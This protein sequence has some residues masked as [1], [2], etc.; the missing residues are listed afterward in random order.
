M[1]DPKPMLP[2]TTGA[3]A[4]LTGARLV[5]PDNIEITSVDSAEVARPGTLTFARSAKYVRTF[6]ESQA[7]AA[8]VNADAVSPDRPPTLPEG[9]ALLVVPSADHAIARLLDALTPRTEVIPGVDASAIISP[10]ARIDPT[11]RVDAYAVIG[12]GTEIGPRVSVG[13]GVVI[14]RNC[15][16]GEGTTI[17]PRVTLYDKVSIGRRCIIHAGVVMGSDGFGFLPAPDGRGLLKIPHVGSVEVHDDVEVGSNST[18]DRGKFGPT[19]IGQ[20]TKIDNLCQIG[21]NCRIGRMCIIC[22]MSGLAGSVTLG[23]GVVIGAKSGVK[24]NLSMG[25]GSRLAGASTVLENVPAGETWM[26][27][28]ARPVM[29]NLR[30]LAEYQRLPETTARFRA[31][32]K[33]L[34]DRIALLEEELRALRES[35]ERRDAAHDASSHVR[36]SHD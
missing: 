9:K 12:A 3:L 2:T 33:Q 26:G 4:A 14:G 32:D 29:E 18:V 17:A 35:Q 34:A 13:V 20:G 15:R 27:S 30:S 31:A 22:G 11:A 6:I 25:P 23:D 16:V 19:I 5:G 36:G 21:H 28:H 7:S 1:S 8:L 10:D 24:D